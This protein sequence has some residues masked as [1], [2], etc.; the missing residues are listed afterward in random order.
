[1]APFLVLSAPSGIFACSL[2]SLELGNSFLANSD[3][4][5]FTSEQH[6]NDTDILASLG[7]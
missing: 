3:Y 5:F 4:C 1:M 6:Q 2:F 7:I